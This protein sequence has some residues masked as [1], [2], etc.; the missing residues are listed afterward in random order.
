MRTQELFDQEAVLLPQR[1][2]MLTIVTPVIGINVGI[3]VN[4]ALALNAASIA[5]TATGIAV[6]AITL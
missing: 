1:E 6:Q 3:G 2:T 5:S 4:G